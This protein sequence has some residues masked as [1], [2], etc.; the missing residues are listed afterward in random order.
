MCRD[1]HDHVALSDL[2]VRI[3]SCLLGDFR[4][5]QLSLCFKVE[6]EKIKL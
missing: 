3:C 5:P 2:K 6:R 4:S 1:L